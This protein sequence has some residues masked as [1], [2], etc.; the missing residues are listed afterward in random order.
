MD[1]AKIGG[2]KA[3]LVDPTHIPRWKADPSTYLLISSNS[4][5]ISGKTKVHTTLRQEEAPPHFGK[6]S[7]ASPGPSEKPTLGK[8]MYDSGH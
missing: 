4:F 8:R 1:A 2:K 7:E 5:F 6:N 3:E